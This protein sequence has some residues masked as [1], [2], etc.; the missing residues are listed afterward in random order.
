MR[1]AWDYQ[2]EYL[3][4]NGLN[5]EPLQF[6]IRNM[7]SRLRL[8][9]SVSAKRVDQWVAN[10]QT[11]QARIL[12]YYKNNSTVIYPPV[13]TTYYNYS[14]LSLTKETPYAITVSRLS[15]YKKVDII[16][17]ACAAINLPLKIIGGG[18]AENT[19]K[20]L[21]ST[22]TTAISFLG[23]LSD[24]EKRSAIAGA[25]QISRAITGIPKANASTG[26]IPKSSSAAKIKH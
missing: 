16:I 22:H 21:A 4:E 3:E 19:L 6:I 20:A 7:L 1:Y 15:N 9:D 18:E 5:K 24:D 17:N 12:K 13:D 11:V 25:L 2:H 14:S 10:S 26:A 8:W 23:R